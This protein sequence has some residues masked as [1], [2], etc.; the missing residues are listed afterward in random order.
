MADQD[1]MDRRSGDPISN[2]VNDLRDQGVV[3]MVVLAKHPAQFRLRD[4]IGEVGSEHPDF[5]E[6]DRIKR[7][8]RDLVAVDLLYRSGATVVPTPASLRFNAIIEKGI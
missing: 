4:L 5:R 7:A 8:V 1:S 6:K 2:E 3:L